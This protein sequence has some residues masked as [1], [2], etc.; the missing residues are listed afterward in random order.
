MKSL[1]L[2][3]FILVVFGLRQC[4]GAREPNSP[5]INNLRLKLFSL[6]MF[7]LRPCFAE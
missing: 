3:L 4:P 5:K 1:R 6:E 7:G 2:K